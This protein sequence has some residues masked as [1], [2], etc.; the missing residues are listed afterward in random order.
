MEQS[1]AA[2]DFGRGLLGKGS[3]WVSKRCFEG[4]MGEMLLREGME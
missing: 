4:A 3:E 1:P 2:M